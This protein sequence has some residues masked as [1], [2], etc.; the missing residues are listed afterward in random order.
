MGEYG[1]DLAPVYDGARP[2]GREFR[3]VHGHFSPDQFWSAGRNAKLIMWLRDPVERLAP[4]LDARVAEQSP[5][6]YLRLRVRQSGALL[7]R[8]GP[9][10][11]RRGGRG[12]QYLHHG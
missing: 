2:N 5:T 10:R 11:L 8:S 1:D 7:G 3:A 6:E 4:K 12:R 9:G